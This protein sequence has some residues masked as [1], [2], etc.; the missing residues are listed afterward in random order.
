[1]SARSDI[2]KLLNSLPIGVNDSIM[3]L[4]LDLNNG[5]RMTLKSGYAPTMSF[6]EQEIETFYDNLR[7]VVF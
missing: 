2:A 5:T 3:T 7:S 1:M 6:S 4:T